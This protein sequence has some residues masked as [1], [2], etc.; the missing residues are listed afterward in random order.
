MPRILLIDDDA[1]LAP[2]LREYF[3]GF[4]LELESATHPAEGLALTAREP[5]D[6]VVL[7]VML[8]DMDGFEVCRRI[9]A[10]G[11]LPVLMLTARGE[12]MDRVVG[13]ELGADDYLSKPFEP[14]ELV[15]RINRILKRSRPAA[16]ADGTLRFAG[17][18]IDRE[19]QQVRVEGR[20]P[21]LT[22]M[23]YRL[24]VLLAESPRKPFSRDE[25]LNALKGVDA[26]LYTRSVDI[27][28]SRLRHKLRP[29]DPIK[30]AWGAGYSLVLPGP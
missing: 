18:E 14:R 1:D 12:V 16:P 23:E 21:R 27:L 13:L 17:L 11:E 25:I 5:P 2:P 20:D 7:D 4:G 22:N 29:L 26:D 10:Q 8:P 30:T 6:L 3:R 28:V 9:R 24:L 19:R 15:A